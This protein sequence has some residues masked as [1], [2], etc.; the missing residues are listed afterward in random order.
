MEGQPLWGWDGPRR[1]MMCPHCN[2]AMM[3]GVGGWLCPWCG[4]ELSPAEP[5]PD[6]CPLCNRPMRHRLD[7]EPGLTCPHCGPGAEPWEERWRG[8]RD[9]ERA[10]VKLVSA[11]C[12]LGLHE[13]TVPAVELNPKSKTQGMR[14]DRNKCQ[15]IPSAFGPMRD[16]L[17]LGDI[18]WSAH[19]QAFGSAHE[20]L[21]D[22]SP[23]WARLD[24]E[25]R[26]HLA[27]SVPDI[28]AELDHETGRTKAGRPMDIAHALSEHRLALFVAAF[29]GTS[30]RDARVILVHGLEARG[31]NLNRWGY[32]PVCKRWHKAAHRHERKQRCSCG[33]W[34]RWG[35]EVNWPQLGRRYPYALARWERE[36]RR[37]VRDDDDRR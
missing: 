35:L 18:Q 20:I 22:L 2:A 27:M 28:M 6:L 15:I 23:R 7:G 24:E 34:I 37:E 9:G 25:D 8:L 16:R 30:D 32:C 33:T 10:V 3:E 14:R 1:V 5:P 21:G 17:L 12:R 11:W 26:I 19:P 31:G 29:G 36:L 4:R 13:M